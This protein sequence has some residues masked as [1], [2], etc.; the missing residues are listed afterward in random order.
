M[1]TIKT[2]NHV[3]IK[4]TGIIGKIVKIFKYSNSEYKYKVRTNT[5][6]Y[7]YEK[8]KDLEFLK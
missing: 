8:K 7:R 2:K 4:G 6:V 5:G 1:G 3:K